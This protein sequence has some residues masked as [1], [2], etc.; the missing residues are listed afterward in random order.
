MV[1]IISLPA[2]NDN[3]IWL[4]IEENGHCV[5]IDPGEAQAVISHIEQLNLTPLAILITH[6]C[7]DH[8]GG[9]AELMAQYPSL[10]LYGPAALSH[11]NG[12]VKN[13]VASSD[14]AP[15]KITNTQ[16][17]FKVISVPG[18]QPDHLVYLLNE[19]CFC[20][21]TLFSA[22]CGRIRSGFAAHMHHSLQKLAKLEKNTLFYPAHEYTQD[23]LIFAH[24][25]EPD[26]PHIKQHLNKVAKLTQQGIPSLP[27]KLTTELTIN[28]FLRCH[29]PAVKQAVQVHSATECSSP[30]QV[31]AQLR[32]WKDRF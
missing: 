31:F 11:E 6:R 13:T 26:N 28:P 14:K 12:F 5:I 32:Q 25:V 3:Y 4:I 27:T 8:I 29:I 21:D 20:G 23:N 7:H 1:K 17:S 22:G 9:V 2:L 16:L 30:E 24:T 18:H 15:L 10:T 19:H